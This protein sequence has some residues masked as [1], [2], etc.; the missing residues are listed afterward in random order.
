MLCDYMEPAG[1]A[2]WAVDLQWF[3]PRMAGSDTDKSMG[4]G[5]LHVLC[6]VWVAACVVGW[7]LVR[8]SKTEYV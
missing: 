1:R 7:S 2:V 5:V 4:I 8:R 3:R 6:V